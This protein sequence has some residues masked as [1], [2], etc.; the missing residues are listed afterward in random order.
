MGR[1]QVVASGH[2]GLAVGWS[3]ACQWPAVVETQ[4]KALEGAPYQGVP[5]GFKVLAAGSGAVQT[6]KQHANGR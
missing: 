3:R 2:S 6:C 1:D 4:G 5:G